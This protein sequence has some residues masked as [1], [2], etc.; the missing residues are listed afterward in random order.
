VICDSGS[1]QK[2]K[3]GLSENQ[4]SLGPECR[5]ARG[6]IWMQ[7]REKHRLWMN[8]VMRELRRQVC[9]GHL[10]VRD[11]IDPIEQPHRFGVIAIR[12]VSGEGV[13]EGGVDQEVS[14]A[15][16]VYPMRQRSQI[17]RNVI[18]VGLPGAC[19]IEVQARVHVYSPGPK[20]GYGNL[21]RMRQNI[22]PVRECRRKNRIRCGLESTESPAQQVRNHDRNGQKHDRKH[23]PQ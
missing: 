19:R 10:P 17:S 3:F 12:W 23:A 15:G 14:E 21:T 4:L 5:D 6:V 2:A 16:M 9:A 11:A 7:M 22:V 8:I 13:I 1:R 18:A 20:G